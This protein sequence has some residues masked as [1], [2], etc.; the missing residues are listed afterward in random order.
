VRRNLP[1]LLIRIVVG[2]VFLTEGILKFLLP[3][4]L[5]AGRFALIGLPVP[6]LL[7]PAVGVVEMVSGAAVLFNLYTGEAA[8]ILLCVIVTALAT[9]KLPILLGHAIGPFP[10]SKSATHRGVLGFLHEARLDLAMLFSLVAILIDSGVRLG[11]PRQW[12]GR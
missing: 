4:E 1:L 12:Y 5:G 9:T 3:E 11:R 7:A 6:H 8:V 10:L 2:I